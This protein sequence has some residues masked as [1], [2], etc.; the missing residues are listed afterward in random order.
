MITKARWCNHHAEGKG[1]VCSQ[2]HHQGE[3]KSNVIDTTSYLEM[4]IPHNQNLC[5]LI[6]RKGYGI[7]CLTSWTAQ[8][9]FKWRSKLK[10]TY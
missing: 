1:D 10:A 6:G 2:E 4:Q 3:G 9:V 7:K 5:L 8:Q